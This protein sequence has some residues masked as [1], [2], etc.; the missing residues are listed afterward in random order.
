MKLPDFKTRDAFVRLKQAMGLPRDALGNLRAVQVRRDGVSYEEIRKL[1]EEG[2]EFELGDI[3]PLKDGTLSYKDRRVLLYIRDVAQ[4]GGNYS[5]PKFHFAD[6]GT[7]QNMR[8]NFRFGR[9]VIA[10]R[11]DGLFQLHYTQTGRKA[12]KELEVCQNCLDRMN[13]NGFTLSAWAT[14]KRQAAV[15]SFSIAEFFARFPKTLHHSIPDH[16][17]RSAPSNVYSKDWG[18]I[19]R[20]Y[21]E[22]RGWL[23]E[24]CGMSLNAP[25]L[26]T[27]LEVHHRNGLKN[28]NHETNLKAVCVHCHANEPGHAHMFASPRYKQFEATWQRLNRT[29]GAR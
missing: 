28:E 21:R 23:C 29:S 26:R 10:T 25:H 12:E 4:Y 7:L 15:S 8:T 27:Y 5:D 24:T 6:C 22:K 18:A 16:T 17:D 20:A 19:S 3:V 11:D 2:L 13:Y 1:S 14:A 9:Y